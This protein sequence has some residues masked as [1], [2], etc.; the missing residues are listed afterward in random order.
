MV[1]LGD[2]GEPFVR[3]LP[4]L[5]LAVDGPG[6]VQLVFIDSYA[7]DLGLHTRFLAAEETSGGGVRSRN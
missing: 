4:R 7:C 3:V 6:G 5:G 2:E 1:A